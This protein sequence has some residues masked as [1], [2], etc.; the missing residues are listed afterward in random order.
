VHLR[1]A[2]A[3]RES[4]FITI[5]TTP[6]ALHDLLTTHG[7]GAGSDPSRVLVV[8]ETCDVAAVPAMT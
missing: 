2:G 8:F 1:R 4:S 3:R 7:I 5:P 6:A